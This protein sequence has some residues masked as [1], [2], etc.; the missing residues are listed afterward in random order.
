MDHGVPIFYYLIQ[1]YH[2]ITGSRFVLTG[3]YVFLRQ[4]WALESSLSINGRY[5]IVHL[6]IVTKVLH[7]PEIK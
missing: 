5:R 7:P 2:A 6:I 4:P 1:C 3:F